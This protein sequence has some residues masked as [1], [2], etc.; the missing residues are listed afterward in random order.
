MPHGC[1]IRSPGVGPEVIGIRRNRLG[2]DVAADRGERRQNGLTLGLS[3][4]LFA[5]LGHLADERL[6]T[7][8]LFVLVGT[9]VGFAAGFWAM[10]RELVIE[11]RKKRE[12]N[13]ADG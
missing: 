13:S 3:T 10:Y 2:G 11:P 7:G 1:D 4:A 12:Q 9:F 5:W 6:Q 8:P